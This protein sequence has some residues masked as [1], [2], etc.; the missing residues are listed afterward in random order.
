MFIE[1]ICI[2]IAL[3]FYVMYIREFFLDGKFELGIHVTVAILTFF[4][5]L[6][7]TQAKYQL[8]A[9]L[10][11]I[12]TAIAIIVTQ[13]PTFIIIKIVKVLRNRAKH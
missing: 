5:S 6:Y 7:I 10:F 9:M 13:I 12:V 1:T 8:E 3:A 2:L 11:L 4:L